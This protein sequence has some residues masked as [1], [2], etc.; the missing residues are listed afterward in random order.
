MNWLK[1][2]FGNVRT[3]FGKLFDSDPEVFMLLIQKISPIVNR[4]YPIVKKIA[5]LTPTKTDD[6]IIAA[7]ESFG[8]HNLFQPGTDPGIALRDLAKKVL[9]STNPDPISDYLANTAIELAYAKYK[10]EQ[11]QQ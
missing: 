5:L 10:E 6:V 2:F 4:A 9:I 3:F 7:Y 11:I 8:L 1:N